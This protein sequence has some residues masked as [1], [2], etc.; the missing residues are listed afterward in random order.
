MLCGEGGHK[1]QQWAVLVLRDEGEGG[2]CP[3]LG[4]APHGSRQEKPLCSQLCA[5]RQKKGKCPVPPVPRLGRVFFQLPWGFYG[6]RAGLG[7]VPCPK[8]RPGTCVGW[9]R[10]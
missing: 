10:F 2:S 4:S 9:A 1:E 6:F 8:S 7:E 5:W 3:A